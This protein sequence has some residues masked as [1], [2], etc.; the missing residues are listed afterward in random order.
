MVLDFFGDWITKLK[1]PKQELPFTVLR[2]FF[3]IWYEKIKINE[4]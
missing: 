4:E 3:R 2:D 1:N